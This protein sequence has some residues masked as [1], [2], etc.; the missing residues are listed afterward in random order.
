MI[1]FVDVEVTTN[2]KGDPFDPNNTHVCTSWATDESTIPSVDFE[3]TDEFRS[4]LERSK[5]IVGFNLKFDLHW[6][7]RLGFSFAEKRG[8]CCQL[9][10]YLLSRQQHRYP[11]LDECAEKYL[12]EKKLDIVKTEYW[13]KGINT[14]QIPRNILSEYAKQDIR[15]TKGVF[16]TQQKLIPDHQKTLFSIQMQDLLVLQEMEWNG[17]KFDE[18]TSTERAKEVEKQI[19]KIQA[20][21]SLYHSVPGFN[22]SSNDHLSALLYGGSIAIKERVPDGHYKTGDKKGQI[23]F[24]I[25]VKDYQL[26]RLFR[27]ARGSALKKDGYFSV[28]EEFL[29]KLKG[30][31]KLLSGIMQIKKLEKRINT[32][33]LGFPKTR[34][35]HN[36]P[37]N[38][39]HTK[40]N[41]C[42]TGTGRLSSSDPNIQNLD[43]E[44]LEL[45]ESQYG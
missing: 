9:A 11:S 39:L 32:Y 17:L 21:L 31:N 14:D 1:L 37:K 6:L 26:P 8:Y 25:L 19:E 3:T 45:F 10:E 5:L 16:L 24:K 27:P 29:T 7:K 35:E 18:D 44:V 2:S 34:I 36:W 12:G 42:V 28:N 30:D 13:D 40:F 38:I 4:A 43:G 15:L 23:K 20:E 33:L 41:Q 22:W